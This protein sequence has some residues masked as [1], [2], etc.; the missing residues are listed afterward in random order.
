[1]RINVTLCILFSRQHLL[2]NV[3]EWNENKTMAKK[4]TAIVY[5]TKKRKKERKT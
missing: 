4:S 5:L 1:M 2:S 3:T